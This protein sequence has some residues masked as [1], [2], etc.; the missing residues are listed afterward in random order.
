MVL[1]QRSNGE[2]AMAGEPPKE[3]GAWSALVAGGAFGIAVI[4][5]VVAVR[6]PQPAAVESIAEPSL[7]SVPAPTPPDENTKPSGTPPQEAR[8]AAQPALR[9]PAPRSRMEKV[10]ARQPAARNE[11]VFIERPRWLERP[12][13]RTIG[14]YYPKSTRRLS[15]ARVVLL[16]DVNG[17]GGLSCAVET[18]DPRNSGFADAAQRI[19][20]HYR[21]AP[22]L[23]DGRSTTGAQTRLTITFRSADQ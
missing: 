1:F 14:R 23:E 8:P 18:E 7:Q 13:G 2:D 9:S 4:V 12:D 21:M 19:A 16:C 3:G 11:R 15:D 20:R 10:I 22:T 6:P 17:G 5:G